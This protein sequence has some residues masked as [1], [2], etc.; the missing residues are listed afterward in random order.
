[1]MSSQVC[2]KRVPEPRD[3]AID[4]LTPSVKSGQTAWTERN[5]YD[6]TGAD[7]GCDPGPN[8]VFDKPA[9]GRL[10]G[11][12]ASCGANLNGGVFSVKK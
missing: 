9:S 5:L 6:F 7:D 2:A 1:M 3:G 8:V 12:T 11:I 10:Y 4:R